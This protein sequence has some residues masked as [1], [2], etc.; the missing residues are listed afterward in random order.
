MTKQQIAH[1]LRL[2]QDDML[3]IATAMDFYGGFNPLYSQHGRELSGAAGL[4][5]EWA[6]EIEAEAHDEPN[7]T[8]A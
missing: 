5:A 3:E 8:T 7:Q 6:D 2:L 4:V 1:K